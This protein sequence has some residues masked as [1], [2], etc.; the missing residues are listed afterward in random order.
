MDEAS[1]SLADAVVQMRH[2]PTLEKL[3]RD[4]GHL[5]ALRLD[6]HIRT[7]SDSQRGLADVLVKL[8]G[9][10]DSS[11]GAPFF[12]EQEV[13]SVLEEIGG[14]D[15]TALYRRLTYSEGTLG[16]AG[17]PQLSG[18]PAGEMRTIIAPDGTELVYQWLDGPTDR[19][20]VYLSGGPGLPPYAAMHALAAPLQHSFD[21]AYLD[22]RGC[23]RSD[24]LGPGGYSV[25]A[26]VDDVEVLRQDLGA[27]RISL[28]GHGWG[29][30]CSLLYAS[31]YPECVDHLILF[32]P[33]PSFPRVVEAGLGLLG[34]KDDSLGAQRLLSEGVRNHSDLQ[35]LG[36]LLD[37]RGAFGSDLQV[38]EDALIKAYDHYRAAFVLPEGLQL[39]NDN[40]LPT[41]LARDHLLSADA[42]GELTPGGYS[43]LIVHGE[44]DEVI[45]LELLHEL[46][47]R[48]GGEIAGVQGAGHLMHLEKPDVVAE[49]IA[50]F[51]ERTTEE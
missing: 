7:R 31:R 5:A 42:L 49:E 43:V 38:C 29:G 41:L 50:A 6:Q 14:E 39:Y 18:P 3:V 17:I 4:K 28:L 1:S 47:K 15:C 37:E 12:T 36:M 21:V 11:D 32:S 22:Q 20:A 19:T 23:G 27:Q 48:V 26:F 44:G 10:G 9:G 40:I 45:S 13:L 30:Y 33:V 46:Q 34:E 51:L 35:R 8:C 25:D 2:N 16:M 24:G